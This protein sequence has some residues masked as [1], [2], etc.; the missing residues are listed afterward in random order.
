MYIV[1]LGKSLSL[2]WVYS[3]LKE[4]R[5]EALKHL[6]LVFRD[7]DQLLSWKN[8]AMPEETQA[9]VNSC[10]H[11]S[12]SSFH[13]GF[14]A[15]ITMADIHLWSSAENCMPMWSHAAN[16]DETQEFWQRAG[17]DC[18][19]VHEIEKNRDPALFVFHFTTLTSFKL[20]N[21]LNWGRNE[22]VSLT[23]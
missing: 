9:L 14:C 21:L 13:F 10:Q 18:S 3:M 20:A 1:H 15:V 2:F 8:W 4:A 6:S 12:P 7:F 11:C 17:R 23:D 16:P 19:S 22:S 5:K